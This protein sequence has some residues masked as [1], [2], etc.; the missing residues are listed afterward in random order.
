MI[1]KRRFRAS[2]ALVGIACLIAVAGC[3]QESSST[4]GVGSPS[5]VI[6]SPGAPS[7]AA[8]SAAASSAAAPS[9]AATSAAASGQVTGKITVLA[10][11]SLNVSFTALGKAFEAANPGTTVT[12]SFGASDML[13]TQINQGAPADVFASA[14]Q[15]TMKTVTS[16]GNATGPKLFA[17]NTLEIAVPPG[18]PAKITG[19]KDFGDKSKKTVVCAKTVPCGSAAQQVFA[20]AKITA[21]PVSYETDVTSALQKVEQNEA[22][23]A[24][25]YK[26]DVASAGNKVQGITFPQASQ[27]VN[28]Y[29]IVAVKDSKNAA[30]AAAFVA[31]VTGPG[32]QLLKK[33][34]FGAP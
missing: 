7:A 8:P 11:A 26:T 34:G 29:P 28:K 1:M 3:G 21:T 32:E 33:D 23:A 15:T 25:V 27:V 6:P 5:A 19:I 10:A 22:D 17:T 14:D 30:T 16:A 4:S 18:N 31:Y 9:A 24:L 12:F 20:L 2:G 13:A